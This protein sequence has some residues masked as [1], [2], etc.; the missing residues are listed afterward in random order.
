MSDVPPATAGVSHRAPASRRWEL[1]FHVWLLF[2]LTL[3]LAPGDVV[4]G[5]LATLAS[6]LHVPAELEQ[7]PGMGLADKLV[8]GSLFAGLGLLATRA[9][10]GRA[11]FGCIML[12]LLLLGAGTEVVQHF[13]PARGASVGDFAADSLGL[14]L[15]FA[16]AWYWRRAIVR[17]Q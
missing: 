11:F 10:L 2:T 4:G 3:L 1:A 13:I 15:G 12:A 14:A 9:W 16:C 6:W 17:R 5:V 8:H 7:V